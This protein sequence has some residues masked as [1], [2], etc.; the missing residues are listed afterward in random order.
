MATISRITVNKLHE[1]ILKRFLRNHPNMSKPDNPEEPKVGQ[2]EL[3]GYG[4]PAKHPNIGSDMLH[5]YKQANGREWNT[6]RAFN[7]KRLLN[8][9]N[10]DESCR[11]HKSSK[12]LLKCPDNYLL[13]YL[14]YLGFQQQS[15]A[16]RVAAFCSQYTNSNCGIILDE[17]PTKQTGVLQ[18]YQFLVHSTEFEDKLLRFEVVMSQDSKHVTFIPY[19][20]GQ[21]RLSPLKGTC[22]LGKLGLRM[23]L[24]GAPESDGPVQ[25]TILARLPASGRLTSELLLV[26]CIWHTREGRPVAQVGALVRNDTLVLQEKSERFLMFK[27]MLRETMIKLVFTAFSWEELFEF[28]ESSNQHIIEEKA[29]FKLIEGAYECYSTSVSDGEGKVR[30]CLLEVFDNGRV[31]YHNLLREELEGRLSFRNQATCFSIQL[32]TMH[33][34]LRDPRY[35][36]TLSCNLDNPMKMMTG[37]FSGRSLHNQPLAGLLAICKTDE[38]FNGYGKA[39]KISVSHQAFQNTLKCHPRLV[40]FLAGLSQPNYIDK[41]L[42]P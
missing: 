21:H 14:T 17:V 27:A 23:E 42:T 12:E 7:P 34:K 40:D 20:E 38:K 1:E 3:Y 30:R 24:Y 36:L 6:E 10:G 37:V 35:S 26:K 18:Q 2:R 15:L 11:L 31:L 22:S 8:L 28:I 29:R 19:E 32:Y 5:T 41:T 39:E 16:S 33:T 4:K 25:M 9:R 13:L